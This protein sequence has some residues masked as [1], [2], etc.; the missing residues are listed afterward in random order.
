MFTL[1]SE[2]QFDT[3]HY[4]SDYQGKCKNIHGH[5]Y[6]LVVKV[7]SQNLHATGHLRGMVEDFS[8]VK[9]ALKKIHD[10]FD[11]KL[12]I[13]AGEEG[14]RVEKKLEESGV[15]FEI[16][17]VPYRPTA[18]EMSRDIYHRLKLD[19]IAVTEVEL[20]ETPTNSCIYTEAY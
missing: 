2:I 20:F 5:R 11:H 12:V 14:E 7:S 17:F 3:A 18:E 4:L 8:S 1:K 9:G 19:G 16:A 6:R 15:L 13:E 10:Q